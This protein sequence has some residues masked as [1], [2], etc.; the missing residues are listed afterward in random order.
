MSLFLANIIGFLIANWRKFVFAALLLLTLIFAVVI[1]KS[2]R[3]EPKIN[4]ETIQ[5]INSETERER[6]A[7]LE[8]VIGE[9]DEKREIS[10]EK[11]EQI[12]KRV[13]EAKSFNKRVTAEELERLIE[14]NK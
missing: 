8:K 2:C 14:E 13:D 7:E 3:R 10:D 12:I 1:F 6:K 4:Q 5:K 11:R 9:I